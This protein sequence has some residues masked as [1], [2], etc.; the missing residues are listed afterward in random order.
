MFVNY[1]SRTLN[2]GDQQ[3]ALVMT[4]GDCRAQW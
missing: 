4:S 1:D 2:V 3:T